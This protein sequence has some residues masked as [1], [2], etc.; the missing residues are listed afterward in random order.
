MF[1]YCFKWVSQRQNFRLPSGLGLF[2]FLALFFFQAKGFAAAPPVTPVVNNV[3]SSTQVGPVTLPPAG[4]SGCTPFGATYMGTELPATNVNA[5]FHDNRPGANNN[6]PSGFPYGLP[7]PPG[8]STAASGADRPNQYW[9]DTWNSGYNP[10][11]DWT[12]AGPNSTNYI[13]TYAAPCDGTYQIFFTL[14]IQAVVQ[15][16][17]PMNLVPT[18]TTSNPTKTIFPPTGAANTSFNF[19]PACMVSTTNPKPFNGG[20]YCPVVTFYFSV[21]VRLAKSQIVNPPNIGP[22]SYINIVGGEFRAIYLHP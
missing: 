3:S 12:P 15:G 2:L 22:P 18:V 21:Q 20:Y 7:A 14:T 9:P 8:I 4:S 10:Q 11:L 6:I 16:T 5:P 19:Y 1:S 13:R 17:N